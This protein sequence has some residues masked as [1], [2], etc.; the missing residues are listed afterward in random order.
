MAFIGTLVRGF[1]AACRALATR[2]GW[3]R[4]EAPYDPW[5]GV[6]TYEIMI[7]LPAPYDDRT[8]TA[9]A[10]ETETVMGGGK[11]Y[12]GFHAGVGIQ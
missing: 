7:K 9:A 6:I 5:K 12:S 10:D 8:P 1:L 11:V 4:R 3:R 2:A